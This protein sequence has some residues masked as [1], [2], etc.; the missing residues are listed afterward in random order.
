M[1]TLQLGQTL[2]NPTGIFIDAQSTVYVSES[3]RSRV[4]KITASG[5]NTVIAGN[6]NFGTT[7]DGGAATSAA[8]AGPMGLMVD[9]FGSDL[10]LFHF[11]MTL[12]RQPRD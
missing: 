6:G 7:G 8:L 4:R 5:V 2:G 11:S 1:A 3:G 12:Q 10:F 9:R